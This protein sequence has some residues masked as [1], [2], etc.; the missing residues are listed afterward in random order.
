M[1]LGCCTLVFSAQLHGLTSELEFVFHVVSPNGSSPSLAF[2][3]PFR[4]EIVC[5]QQFL[6]KVIERIF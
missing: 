6:E 1:L 4:Q 3:L 5:R 2:D